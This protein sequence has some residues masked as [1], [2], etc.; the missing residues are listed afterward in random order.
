MFKNKYLFVLTLLVTTTSYSENYIVT[1]EN[2]KEA[3]EV[4]KH[5]KEDSGRIGEFAVS[6]NVI[7]FKGNGF[8]INDGV[9][10]G[11]IKA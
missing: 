11:S 9:L 7:I 3:K 4:L 8:L 2:K 10:K 5:E 6:G 1:Q